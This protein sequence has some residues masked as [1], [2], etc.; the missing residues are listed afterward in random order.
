[1]K[2][3]TKVVII[4]AGPA[5][6][7]CA[8]ELVEN[9]Q[10]RDVL[11]LEKN[12]SVGGLSRTINYKG[13]Y[14]DV[15]PHRFYTKNNE[16]LSLWKKIGGKDLITDSRLTRIYY[17]NKFFLYPVQFKDVILKLG[18]KENFLCGVSFLQAKIMLRKLEPKTFE[19]WITKNFGSKLYRMF[20]KTYTEKVWG[21]PCKKIGASWATQRIKNMSFLEAFK[22]SVLGQR[23]RKAKSLVDH[24]YYPNLGS[25]QMYRK[26]AGD[27]SRA[28]GQISLTSK[29]TKLIRK[30]KTIV[31]VEYNQNGKMMSIPV[32]HLFSSMP[33]TELVSLLSPKADPQI[34]K[35][36]QK[37]YFHDHIT[38]NL[39]IKQK[40]IF[41]DNWI[42]IHAS[43][44]EMARIANFGN[45]SAKMVQNKNHSAVC[46]E[47]FVFQNEKLW[48]LSD[49]E[50]IDLASAELEKIGLVSREDI[51]EGFVARETES[52][53]TYYLGYEKYYEKIKNY[54]NGF[55]NLQAIGRGGM[56]KY[57][58]MDHSIYSGMLGA[59]NLISGKKQYDLWSINEDAEYLEERK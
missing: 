26:L 5:G 33:L 35:A 40:N 10:G 55:T 6:L 37:L 56:Y 20:F 22:T 15:G 27:I 54:V 29:V 21:I 59:R 57:N 17:N 39:I 51:S 49:K 31:A 8:Y 4:G 30:N 11:V 34:L 7:G 2:K 24:F 47:Y 12:D 46:A 36:A 14:F 43:E 32:S 19:E 25:G 52:Y 38:V 28:G 45:F 42:Y 53:P 41:L 48:K 44:V 3:A 16:V 23:S 18:L 1:M 58:N 13:N 50:I 9:R